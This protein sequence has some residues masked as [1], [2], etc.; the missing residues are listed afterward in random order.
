MVPS[1]MSYCSIF[2]Y[3]NCNLKGEE[4]LPDMLRSSIPRNSNDVKTTELIEVI[5]INMAW[6]KEN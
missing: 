1:G 2:R 4:I 3:A 6:L 5:I